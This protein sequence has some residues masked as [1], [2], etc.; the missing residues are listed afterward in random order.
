M[1]EVRFYHLTQSSLE[2]VLPVML[3]RTCARGGCAVI[4]SDIAD[5]LAFLNTHLWTHDEAGFLA[6]GIDGDPMPERHPIWLTTGADRPNDAGTVF[7]IDGAPLDVAEASAIDITAIVFD[8]H[9][10]DAVARARG[11]WRATTAAGLKAVYWAQ[12]DGSW[13]KAHESG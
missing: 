7:L 3:E 5:R 4:R 2:Q 8:G 1:S 6:H 13:K 10:A 11:Q 12:Q 9:D